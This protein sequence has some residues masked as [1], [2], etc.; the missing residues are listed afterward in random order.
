MRHRKVVKKLNRSASHRKATLV[1]LA[2]A[3]FDKKRIQTTEAKAKAA[4][5]FSE[6]L[7]T[8][9]KRGDLHA[10]RLALQRLRNKKIVKIL[11][12]EIAP[13]F[14]DRN[15]GYT[16]VIK[17][18]QRMGDGAHLSILELVGYEDLV[19][20]ARERKEVKTKEKQ[21]KRKEKETETE[22]SET[23]G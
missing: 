19:E 21:K 23:E 11:F 8:L 3:L 14:S 16:R 2:Q 1:N 22:N 6:K 4:R 5:S 7:I 15:G 12:D 13:K 18:G 20:K 9:A 10:R 17:L